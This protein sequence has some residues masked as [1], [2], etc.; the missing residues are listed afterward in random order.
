MSKVK[1]SV[2]RNTLW[3]LI[4]LYTTSISIF[5]TRLLYSRK[6]GDLRAISCLAFW[7]HTWSPPFLLPPSRTLIH[8]H[9][10]ICTS[11]VTEIFKYI[12]W[13]LRG[14]LGFSILPF[15]KISPQATWPHEPS[16]RNF[17]LFLVECGRTVCVSCLTW[18]RDDWTLRKP[19]FVC[20][21]GL[22]CGPPKA[23]HV[24][25]FIWCVGA[26]QPVP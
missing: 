12:L 22:D 20:C 2:K 17:W 15:T 9:L 14:I 16:T 10:R 18:E 1:L 24:D 11:I 21:V 25:G 8:W 3:P 4:S 5:V 13:F 23:A 26:A 19:V 7:I 6:F